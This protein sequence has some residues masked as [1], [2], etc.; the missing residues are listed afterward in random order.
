MND[1][2]GYQENVALTIVSVG[3]MVIS[4][5]CQFLSGLFVSTISS[6]IPPTPSEEI[7]EETTRPVIETNLCPTRGTTL[8]VPSDCG[9]RR[10]WAD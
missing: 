9:P 7:L 2:M 10:P 6:S 5:F 1:I 3:V 8:Q 4:V